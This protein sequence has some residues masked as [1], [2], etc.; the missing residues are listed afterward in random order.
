MHF[1]RFT[2]LAALVGPAAAQ[3]L[4]FLTSL[5]QELQSLGLTSLINA[6]ESINS[7]TTGQQLLATLGNGTQTLFA[8]NNAGC[9]F[10][11]PISQS[12]PKLAWKWNV[13]LT[14]CLVLFFV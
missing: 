14:G 13:M 10:M 8:P 4:T 7:T 2:A 5:L 11:I 6:T 9:E 1:A 3:N 12:R